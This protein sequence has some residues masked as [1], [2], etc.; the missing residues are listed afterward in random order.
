MKREEEKGREGLF[1]ENNPKNIFIVREF[2]RDKES[3]ER[4]RERERE[5]ERLVVF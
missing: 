1:Q 2:M 5:S 4:E 3:L